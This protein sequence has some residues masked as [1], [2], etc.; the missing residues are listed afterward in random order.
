MDAGYPPDAVQLVI[1]DEHGRFL[2]RADLAWFL[3]D[4]RVVPVELDGREEHS[5]PEAVFRDRTRQNRLVARGARMLRYTGRD[6]TR[7]VVVADVG[8]L[9]DREGWRPRPWPADTPF[10]LS[11]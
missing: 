6:V 1:R 3:S 8:R 2:A 7:G 4:G 11:T 5:T 9:L 10:I